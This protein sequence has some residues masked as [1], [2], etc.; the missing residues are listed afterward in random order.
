VDSGGTSRSGTSRVSPLEES[1]GIGVTPT[2]FTFSPGPHSQPSDQRLFRV[3]SVRSYAFIIAQWRGDVKGDPTRGR[4]R[5]QVL[6]RRLG[7]ASVVPTFDV[8]GRANG[9]IRPGHPF[10]WG[11]R[12]CL[13]HW[14][15]PGCRCLTRPSRFGFRRKSTCGQGLRPWTAGASRLGQRRHWSLTFAVPVETDHG[16]VVADCGLGLIGSYAVLWT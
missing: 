7:G 16:D 6:R 4:G 10:C 3:P 14:G 2:H 15:D 8:N 11:F 13:G 1:G 5:R 12:A 9:A